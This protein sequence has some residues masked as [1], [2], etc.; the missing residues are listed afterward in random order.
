M[1]KAFR[2]CCFVM[3]ILHFSSNIYAQSDTSS[4]LL[5]FYNDF[6]AKKGIS[7]INDVSDQHLFGLRNKRVVDRIDLLLNKDSVADFF[8]FN[9]QF[10]QHLKSSSTLLRLYNILPSKYLYSNEAFYQ[11][12]SLLKKRSSDSLLKK[13]FA[14]IEHSAEISVPFFT[15]NGKFCYLVYVRHL[16]YWPEAKVLLFEWN[17]RGWVLK[18]EL[19]DHASIYNDEK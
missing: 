16:Y 4:F 18:E 17:D 13:A 9:K 11:A 15:N 8:V 6:L 10:I 12:D 5:F 3:I 14:I 2:F 7:K 19:F 1:I